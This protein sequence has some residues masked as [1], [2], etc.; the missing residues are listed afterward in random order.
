MLF[1]DIT[2]WQVEAWCDHSPY[3]KV[4]GKHWS[5]SC[6]VVLFSMIWL[7]E[8]LFQVFTM[9]HLTIEQLRPSGPPMMPYRCSH[10]LWFSGSSKKILWLFLHNNGR[11]LSKQNMAH[12]V[13]NMFYRQHEIRYVAFSP[14]IS[15][16]VI[17]K[18]FLS[19]FFQSSEK[20]VTEPASNAICKNVIQN[21]SNS[22]L[23]SHVLWTFDAPRHIRPLPHKT[24]ITMARGQIRQGY[25]E[26]HY[27]S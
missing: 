7:M 14:S 19:N 17:S 5:L 10:I 21:C 27:L 2:K 16:E 8:A 20:H 12:Y 13:A 22:A 18:P 26:V 1:N 3:R 4:L 11:I 23:L 25:K 6:C 15:F 9:T 24:T